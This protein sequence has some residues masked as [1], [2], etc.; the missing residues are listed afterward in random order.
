MVVP[1]RGR[2]IMAISEQNSLNVTGGSLA[3]PNHGIVGQTMA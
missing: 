2:G 1:V 3:G